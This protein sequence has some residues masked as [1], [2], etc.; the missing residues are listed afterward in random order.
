MLK[1]INYIQKY[2]FKQT[3][4]EIGRSFI[5]GH[6]PLPLKIWSTA[7]CPGPCLKFFFVN[8]SLIRPNQSFYIYFF[9]LSSYPP[10]LP[11]L[12]SPSLPTL[13][14][15]SGFDKFDR[16]KADCFPSTLF[17]NKNAPIIYSSVTPKIILSIVLV[18]TKE[19]S[20][21]MKSSPQNVKMENFTDKQ[22][23]GTNQVGN[24]SSV[25]KCLCVDKTVRY[26]L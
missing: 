7:F 24:L 10:S 11:S 1:F 22:T 26:R 23:L 17:S 21:R 9:N 4:N 13:Y 14:R 5:Q 16:C 2:F 6:S 19:Q 25:A 18:K 8:S 15:R 3:N 12:R 20:K